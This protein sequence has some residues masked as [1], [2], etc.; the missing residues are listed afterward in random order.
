MAK[1]YN[2]FINIVKTIND[3]RAVELLLEWDQ[4]TFMPVQGVK[5]RS[6]QLSTIS[7][8]IH[9]KLTSK[10]LNRLLIELQKIKNMEKLTLEQNAN[11]REVSWEYHR[12]SAVPAELV[13]EISKA[14]SESF[15]EWGKARSKSDF[16]IFEPWLA[17]IIELKKKEAEAIGY[18]KCLYDAMLDGFEPGFR[19]SEVETLFS[20]LRNKL[21]RIVSKVVKN[22]ERPDISFITSGFSIQKQKKFNMKLAKEIGFDF[23]KG[24]LDEA[25]HPFTIG[26]LHDTRITTRYDKN[27][28]RPALF[29]TIHEGGHAMYEQGYLDEHYGTPM[30]QPVSFGIHES[31][32]RMW[33]NMIGRSLPFWKYY[34]PKLQKV[35]PKQ[36]GK[37]S[38]G[39]FYAAINDVHSS[40][41][42]VEAD[43]A[44][45]NL[46]ILLRFELENAIFSDKL[47]AKE[48]PQ[49]WNEKVR[50][51]FKLD[52][53]DDSKG[54][55]QDIHWSQGYFGYFPTYTLGNLYAA[56]FYKQANKDIPNLVEQI[57][58][59]NFSILLDWLRKNIHQ[60][61]K[62]LRADELVKDVT[63]K[64]LDENIFIK[65]LRD[66]YK[67]LY[68][69]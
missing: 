37:R 53:P 44:T 3:L 66:K 46:H 52:V 21:V 16:K 49:V 64:P 25:L 5:D 13:K 6:L 58:N 8:L 39:A 27:D 56:Q 54:V 20:G 15:Q 41:I 48:T 4:Q 35:F 57:E 1:K 47:E 59:G 61:G 29:A 28:I 38:V 10:K 63:G 42:R 24:R 60:K 9:E 12:A 36:L 51:F 30:A 31:Q 2:D 40:F 19:S 17:K 11:V 67:S 14:K 33:E 18:E 62:L 69:F 68:Q 34:Y 32:S 45:Y 7:S 65:Y 55:L 43:E 23:E 50:K 26:S 22:G